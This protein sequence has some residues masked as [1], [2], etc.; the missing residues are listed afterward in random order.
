M[1]ILPQDAD[2][3]SKQRKI[4]GIHDLVVD[5]TLTFRNN[6]VQDSQMSFESLKGYEKSH[7]RK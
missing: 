3:M 2:F 4:L 1:Y 5:I 7:T 6:S